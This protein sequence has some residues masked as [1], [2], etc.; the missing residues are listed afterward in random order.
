MTLGFHVHF[1][2]ETSSFVS[3]GAL[4]SKVGGYDMFACLLA[5]SGPRHQRPRAAADEPFDTYLQ[6]TVNRYAE[7]LFQAYHM[8]GP[9]PPSDPYLL[10]QY[11][12]VLSCHN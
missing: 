1:H 12:P 2:L 7:L 9:C 4:Q 8:C 6:V 11:V 10:V 5:V 3:K